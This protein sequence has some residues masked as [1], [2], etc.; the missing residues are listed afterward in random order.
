[1]SMNEYV[2]LYESNGGYTKAHMRVD[3][4]DVEDAASKAIEKNPTWSLGSIWVT[5][6]SSLQ[7]VFVIS[8]VTFTATPPE[9][10]DLDGPDGPLGRPTV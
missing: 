2:V 8:K 10:E 7:R 9:E 1:M 3:A 6:A 5:L 4:E